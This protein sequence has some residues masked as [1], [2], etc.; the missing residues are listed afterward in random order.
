MQTLEAAGFN[1]AQA[2]IDL[3]K[4]A[5]TR[6]TEEMEKEDAGTISPMESKV[7]QFMKIACDAAKELANYAYPKLKAIEQ[8]R[9]NPTQDMTADQKL[10]AAKMMVHVLEQ[11]AKTHDRPG[12]A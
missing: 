12:D 5:M 9:V 3:H 10:E 8:Q 2:L 11:Q 6:M 1:P 4:I 7:P